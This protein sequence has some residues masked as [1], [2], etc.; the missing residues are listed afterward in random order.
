MRIS[1]WSS[2][3]CSSDLPRN[4]DSI[5][6]SGG[7]HSGACVACKLD[8]ETS[9]AT[10][11]RMNQDRLAARQTDAFEQRLPGRAGGCGN[12]SRV[13]ERDCRGRSDERRVGKE[14]VRQCRSRWSPYHYK[15]KTYKWITKLDKQE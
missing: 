9:D 1:D 14:C 2:D 8:C 10:C 3:V 5:A 7:R 6:G 15:K 4:G 13:V 12:S 11:A